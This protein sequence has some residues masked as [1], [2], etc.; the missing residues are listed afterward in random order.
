MQWLNPHLTDDEMRSLLE[1]EFPAAQM[2]A[3][4]VNTIRTR[5]ADDM[6][7]MDALPAASV[8]PLI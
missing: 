5:K 3:W 1:F 2:E 4:A 6:Q 7:V 8:P